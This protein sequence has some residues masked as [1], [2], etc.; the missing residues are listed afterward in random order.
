[1]KTISRI[2]QE[3]E[4]ESYD[5]PTKTITE[6]VEDI[7]KKTL[8]SNPNDTQV[9][10]LVNRK[11]LDPFEEGCRKA[12]YYIDHKGN[13]DNPERKGE[14]CALIRIFWASK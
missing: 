14:V 8:K 9:F 2:R 1:M 5:S 11:Y 7:I 3:I 6:N 4:E 13:F 10:V 12:G